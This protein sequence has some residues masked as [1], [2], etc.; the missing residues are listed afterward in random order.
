MGDRIVAHI[1]KRVTG[2]ASIFDTLAQVLVVDP[3]Q[4]IPIV[5]R[6]V[7]QDIPQED[8]RGSIYIPESHNNKDLIRRG[9]VVAVGPGDKY[10]EHGFDNTSQVRRKLVVCETCKGGPFFRATPPGAD[11]DYLGKIEKV[12]PYCSGQAARLPM[13]VKVGDRVLYS[14]RK[15]LEISIGGALYSLVNV[16]QSIFAVLEDE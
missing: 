5:D 11:N 12:C 7:I 16:E 9:L 8:R 1:E 3:K 10:T 13:P 15:D 6:C 4:I 14:K 2:K